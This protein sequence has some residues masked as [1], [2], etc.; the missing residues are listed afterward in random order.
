MSSLNSA[1]A[2]PATMRIAIPPANQAVLV[3]K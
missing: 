1:A 3:L 2:M